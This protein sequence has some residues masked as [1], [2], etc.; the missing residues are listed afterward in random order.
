MW[1]GRQADAPPSTQTIYVNNAYTT[2]TN[3][4]S[5]NPYHTVADGAFATMPGDVVNIQA[6]T[7][8]EVTRF[9]RAARMTAVNGSVTIKQ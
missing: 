4:S 6:G 5:A 7:Y 9:N 2:W 8:H 3:G 1:F